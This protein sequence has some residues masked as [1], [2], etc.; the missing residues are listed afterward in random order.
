LHPGAVA[1]SRY[2]KRL[3]VHVEL[4][5][6]HFRY[7]NQIAKLKKF[8]ELEEVDQRDKTR[9]HPHLDVRSRA[10]R[11]P[12]ESKQS[13]QSR[14][15]SRSRSTR[16]G[17]QAPKGAA[18]PSEGPSQEATTTSTTTPSTA[19]LP[20][21]VPAT[22][23]ALTWGGP[24]V[25]SGASGLPESLK[26]ASAR[27]SE[28]LFGSSASWLL[29][30]PFHILGSSSSVTPNSQ[31]ASPLAGPPLHGSLLGFVVVEEDDDSDKE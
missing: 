29:R 27:A 21:H 16:A 20:K 4:S 31:G 5:D 2:L 14:P 12:R 17:R 1:R 13:H 3:G 15:R 22:E 26:P 10:R 7:P 25:Y 28:G 18:D 6:R 23:A 24:W 19:V 11:G 9:K 30:S 8:Y